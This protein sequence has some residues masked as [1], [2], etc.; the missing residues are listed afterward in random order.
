[1]EMGG[2]MSNEEKLIKFYGEFVQLSQDDLFSST[3]FFQ[4]VVTAM[5]FG[6]EFGE[7]KLTQS[8]I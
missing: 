6:Y 8:G 1:M 7:K 4:T 5:V 2:F 3:I